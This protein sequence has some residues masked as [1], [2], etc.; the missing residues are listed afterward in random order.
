M[1]AADDF[2]SLF[3]EIGRY[4]AGDGDVDVVFLTKGGV[5]FPGKLRFKGGL[6]VRAEMER[7]GDW[8][9]PDDSPLSGVRLLLH[10]DGE[11]PLGVLVDEGRVAQYYRP[12]AGAT[13]EEF[14]A[15][16]QAA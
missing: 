6:C 7:S 1:S 16:L 3:D 15:N 14:L 10:F 12:V 8:G 2:K 11:Q 9:S 13:R 5:R 4:K